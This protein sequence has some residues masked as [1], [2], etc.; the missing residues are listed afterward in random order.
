MPC[1][2]LGL[3]GFM[4]AQ[5]SIYIYVLRSN[6][7]GRDTQLYIA[8]T[9]SLRPPSTPPYL[10]ITFS[11]TSALLSLVAFGNDIFQEDKRAAVLDVIA[12]VIPVHF[13]WTAGTLSLTTYRPSL[14]V[15]GQH[16][17]GVIFRSSSARILFI[18]LHAVSED[19]FR[20]IIKSRRQCQSMGVV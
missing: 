12:M 11:V 19:T 20:Q 3:F 1:Q 15:A 4:G 16:D 10:F 14:N 13:A 17:V 6:S 2:I 5:L 8:L 18:R 9:A 7:S